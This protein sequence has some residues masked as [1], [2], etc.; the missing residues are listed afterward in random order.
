MRINI[1]KNM[2]EIE[3][4]FSI[5]YNETYKTP[6]LY[7]IFQSFD[8]TIM[9]YHHISNHLSI[10]K[11]IVIAQEEH[12][13]YGM[14]YYTVHSCNMN[15]HLNTLIIGDNCAEGT[16]CKLLAWLMMI[17]PIINCKISY[18]DYKCLHQIVLRE[19]K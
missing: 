19:E 9:P 5:I 4:K 1:S 16:G 13:I 2:N 6:M 17:L 7:F 11:N 12:P 8:G 10:N 15:S 3:C 14:P 18:G